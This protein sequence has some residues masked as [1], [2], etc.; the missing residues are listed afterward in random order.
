MSALAE[1]KT[2]SLALTNAGTCCDA[3]CAERAIVA[4]LDSAMVE[5]AVCAE[6][7]PDDAIGTKPLVWNPAWGPA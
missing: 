4:V 2:C 6:H 3:P 5:H 7:V 1:I